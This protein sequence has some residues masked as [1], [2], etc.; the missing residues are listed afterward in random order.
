MAKEQLEQQEVE[1]IAEKSKELAEKSVEAQIRKLQKKFGNDFVFK[2]DQMPPPDVL[3]TRFFTIN[4]LTGFNGLPKGRIIEL[5][6]NEGSGKTTLALTLTADAQRAGMNAL[7][8]DLEYK[9]IPKYAEKLG[10]D[11]SKL[12]LINP[13][14]GDDA[15]MAVDKLLDTGAIG[16]IVIDSVANLSTAGEMEK[17]IFEP[18]MALTARLL[19][20]SIRRLIGKVARTKAIILFINQY[21]QAIGTMWGNPDRS[22]GGNALQYGISL[23]FGL[24][25]STPIKDGPKAIGNEV[26]VTIMKN[27]VGNPHSNGVMELYYGEGFNPESDMITSALTKEVLT[28]AGSYIK[29]DGVSI[30]QGRAELVQR[31]KTDMELR[32]NLL[33]RLEAHGD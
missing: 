23:K 27:Q 6:G 15:M 30:S 31:L 1:D 14:T 33:A 11:P 21:R 28:T 26:K 3:K 32:S 25:T 4:S 18:N 10:V 20:Q 5:V 24:R 19:S 8:V 2:L 17:E 29:L 13:V 22:S 16:F 12:I 9:V 7:Y